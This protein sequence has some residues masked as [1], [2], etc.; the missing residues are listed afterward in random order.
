MWIEALK[1]A[2]VGIVL[3]FITLSFLAF[4][5]WLIG[6]FS[7]AISR[8]IEKHDV[9]FTG[10]DQKRKIAVITAAINQYEEGE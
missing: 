8:T 4:L 10:I 3:V 1:I 6:K 2:G 9:V 5:G 7:F